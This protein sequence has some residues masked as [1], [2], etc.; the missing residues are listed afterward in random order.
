MLLSNSSHMVQQ[1]ILAVLFPGTANFGSGSLFP[2]MIDEF[3]EEIRLL[4]FTK[5]KFIL[6]V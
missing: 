3:M 5:H 2:S 6:A 1:P 4:S